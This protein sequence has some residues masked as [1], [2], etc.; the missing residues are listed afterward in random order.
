[1]ELTDE[2]LL[3]TLAGI[4]S[5][6]TIYRLPKRHCS[7][8]DALDRIVG[9][10]PNPRP[11]GAA[12]DPQVR[13]QHIT[14]RRVDEQGVTPGCPR[15]EGRGMMTLSEGCRKRFESTE[16]EKL[17]KQLE[18]ATRNAEPPPVI[19]ADMDVEQ[20][21]EQPSTVAASSSSVLAQSGQEAVPLSSP[22]THE[23][24][25]ETDEPSIST[26]PLE[27]KSSSK[28][29]RSL[30]GSLKMTRLET[31]TSELSDDQH[32]QHDNIDH[33]QQPDTD[34]SGVWRCQVELKSDLYGDK[35]G[36]LMDPGKVVKGTL[37]E[38][39]HMHD[40]HVHDWID[41]QT[42]PRAP[43]L[44]L[45][46][47]VTTSSRAMAMRPMSKVVLSCSSTMTSTEM[48]SIKARHR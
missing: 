26:R 17:D 12:R 19:A 22:S 47:G 18:E 46:G 32:D 28:R 42:F 3:G 39:K 8:R 2:H 6:R 31:R 29:A 43:R 30:A 1:M 13:R 11:D 23:V 16:K 44:R 14:Q 9:T 15:C 24:T 37:T 7:S 40:H 41:K 38:L 35:T 48:M 27:G 20:P 21:L 33:M 36:K 10:H 45:R 5:S 34:I 4:R 25:T